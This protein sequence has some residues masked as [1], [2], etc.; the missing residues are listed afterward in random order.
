MNYEVYIFFLRNANFLKNTNAVS[1][2]E[3]VHLNYMIWQQ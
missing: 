3:C 2:T 1:V